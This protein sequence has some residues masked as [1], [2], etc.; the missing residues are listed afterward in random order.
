METRM[1]G[2]RDTGGNSE[3]ECMGEREVRVSE[4]TADM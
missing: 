1:Q 3:E 2:C 4:N